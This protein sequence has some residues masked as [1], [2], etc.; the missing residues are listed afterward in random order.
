MSLLSEENE[1]H[2]WMSKKESRDIVETAAFGLLTQLCDGSLKGRKAVAAAHN[3]DRCLNR[4]LAI[5]SDTT[6]ESKEEDTFDQKEEDEKKDESSTTEND[7]DTEVDAPEEAAPETNGEEKVSTTIEVANEEHLASAFA[8]LS[9]ILQLS[10]IRNDLLQNDKF[11]RASAALATDGK[12]PYLQFESVKVISRLAPCA[13]M[14]GTLPPDRVGTILQ[15]ALGAEPDLKNSPGQ[16]NINSLHVLA[17]E[18]IEYVFDSLS[19]SQQK[20][21]ISA[22]ASRYQKILRTHSI[23]RSS[24]RGTALESGGELAYNLTTVLMMANGRTNLEPCFDSTVLTSLVN[25]VQ[26]RYDPK[27]VIAED[28]LCFW[29]AS[30]THSL[31]ILSQILRHEESRMEKSG[32]KKHSLINTVLMVARP[33]KAPRKAI[34]FPSALSLVTKNG[35]AAAKLAAKRIMKSLGL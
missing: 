15:L 12:H 31:Q 28:E 14:D 29:D 17:T 4:A 25:T 10:N 18:G 20:S 23:A 32:L 22:I 1:E 7:K 24:T 35:E 21:A 27:T 9:T 6:A 33:G 16:W 8:F 2:K 26:W 11:I 30:V 3:F 5:L 13:S 34:D 19:E